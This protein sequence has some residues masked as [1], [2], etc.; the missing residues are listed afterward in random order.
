[1]L[2]LAVN[3]FRGKVNYVQEA[4]LLPKPIVLRMKH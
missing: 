2:R 1:M 4:Q 3:L